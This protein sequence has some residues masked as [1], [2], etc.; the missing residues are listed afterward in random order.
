M[1]LLPLVMHNFN[2]KRIDNAVL[3]FFSLKK[4]FFIEAKIRFN[5][6]ICYPLMKIFS[7]CL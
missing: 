6:Y 5:L 7:K 2:A 1:L 3:S 4:F